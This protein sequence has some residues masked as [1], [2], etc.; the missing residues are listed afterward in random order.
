MAVHGAGAGPERAPDRSAAAAPGARTSS[1][2]AVTGWHAFA[3]KFA[4]SVTCSHACAVAPGA[5]VTGRV[6]TP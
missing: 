3:G 1:I 5:S 4:A 2:R 6:L